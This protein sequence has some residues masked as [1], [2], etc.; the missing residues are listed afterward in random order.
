[1]DWTDTVADTQRHTSIVNRCNSALA[2]GGFKRIQTEFPVGRQ[3]RGETTV[4]SIKG[5]KIPACDAKAPSL[6]AAKASWE[7][8]A[9]QKPLRD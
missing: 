2:E 6:R 3:S 4:S 8:L 5:F 9:I 1:M 7:H